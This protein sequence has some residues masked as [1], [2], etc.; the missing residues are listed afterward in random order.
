VPAC[1]FQDGLF[2]T[3]SRSSHSCTGHS[4]RL[5]S[6]GWGA[7]YCRDPL[8]PSASGEF[9]T[10]GLGQTTILSG[11]PCIA[12]PVRKWSRENKEKVWL[13]P[14]ALSTCFLAVGEASALSR[15][16]R[17]RKGWVQ[18]FPSFCCQPSLPASVGHCLACPAPW[19]P[20][21]CDR[22]IC[23]MAWPGLGLVLLPLPFLPTLDES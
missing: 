6:W 15:L 1:E 9:C 3:L 10:A 23:L 8:F 11:R 4:S 12:L 16:L 18:D 2:F 17:G 21:Q 5:C 20:T 13:P 19:F 22:F 7:G 14:R